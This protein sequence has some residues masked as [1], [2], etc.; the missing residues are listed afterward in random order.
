VIPTLSARTTPDDAQP[1]R[2]PVVD[3][4]PVQA[5]GRDADG[6]LQQLEATATGLASDE[7]ERRLRA[8]GPNEIDEG[9]PA[10]VLT[11]LLH[12]FADV[13]VWAL[14]AAAA[15][16]F[17]LG[18]R[19]EGGV[20]ARFGDAIA[21]VVIIAMNAVIGFA[22]ERKAE[23]ALRAL[24]RLGAPMATVLRD[25][26]PC[27]LPARV[28]VPGDVVLL[29]EGDRV[30]ADGRMLEARE[31]LT[32]EAA[33]TGESTPVE[34]ASELVLDRDT[35]LAERANSV[36]AGTHVVRGRG[37]AVVVAT[38]METELGRIAQLLGAV[39]TPE[40]PLQVGLRHFGKL[41]VLGCVAIS[42]VVFLVTWLRLG[43]G[44]G[45]ALLTAVSLAVA[46]IPE[47]LPAVT[48]I[49]L[50]LG[51]QR[52]AKEKALIRRLSAVETLGAATVI[53]TDKTGTLTQNRM[54]VRRVWVGGVSHEA[55]CLAT[56]LT[57]GFSALVQAAAHAP[58]ATL[59][60]DGTAA[61]DPTD[62]ALLQ[63]HQT[64]ASEPKVWIRHRVLPFDRERKLASVVTESDG[65]L[66]SFTHGAPEAVLE[67]SSAVLGIDGTSAPLGESARAE[68]AGV[69]EELARAGLRVIALASRPLKDP[70]EACE[71]DL[72]FL[73][74]VGIADP[75]RP[76]VKEA[77]LRARGAGVKSVMITGDH[78]LT[79]EAIAKEIGLA[80][81]DGLVLTGPE[82]DRLSDAELL[83]RVGK[84]RVVARAT[85]ANKL[86]LVNALRKQ[87]EVVAM[88]GDGVNDA[89]AIKAADI[90]VAMGKSGTDV[91]REASDMVLLDDNYA[92][93]VRAIS[94]GRIVYSNIKRFIIFLFSAN[95]ALVLAVF[96][97]AALGWPPILTPTQILW[98]NLITNGLPALALGMEPVHIDPMRE[99]PRA[100]S[101]GFLSRTELWSIAK[102]GAVMAILGLLAFRL[103]GDLPHARTL[104]FT[105]LAF[106]PLF[107]AQSR[108]SERDPI[109][110]LGVLSNWRLCGALVF[111]V[112]L[113]AV[114]L[115]VPLLN[116]VFQ[117]RPLPLL[118]VVMALGLSALVLGLGELE[119]SLRDANLARSSGSAQ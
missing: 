71:R 13:T 36:F 102:Y 82:I 83:E 6:T 74:L 18:F 66:V 43:T 111:A 41:V 5:W 81:G 109:W 94:E 96:V 16:A 46:A 3:A 75:P 51:V 65:E 117:T 101:A 97:A 54:L 52:M 55:S 119:K 30:P 114:A 99:T 17:A 73:G 28:L 27:E 93:I 84:V 78:P 56:S 39:S 50:A 77:I 8:L 58:A 118:E 45:V 32:S 2:R 67:R 31:L 22:E 48:T 11:Q 62:A 89:P 63:F 14:L 49:V 34:K 40:T 110:K 38:G 108:R 92:T 9:K 107:H 59:A 88:T 86:R 44:L 103:G 95:A 57:R 98:I 72:T 35:P 80:N 90:G 23:R 104:A 91:T 20:L 87:G 37:R 76:E 24:R 60:N 25:G 7:A 64:F 33:L 12:Q 42:L 53:C 100:A 115:Y 105:V 4:Q 69:V 15:L 26:A 19:E 68:I 47:G 61:G 112:G 116:E 85:A 1:L 106:A 21:I 10:S 70:S 113:Q 79:G 29:R